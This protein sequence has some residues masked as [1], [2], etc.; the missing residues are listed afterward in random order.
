MY[1]PFWDKC[2]KWPQRTLKPT[3]SN[4]PITCVTWIPD[5]PIS[6]CFSLWPVVSE[7]QA[8]LRQMHQMNPQMT[9]EHYK[10]KATP[11]V[12]LVSQ[13]PNFQS[14]SLYDQLFQSY[15]S[16]DTNAL[17]DPQMTLNTRS[18]VSHMHVNRF[19]DTF[20]DKYIKWPWTLQGQIYP[21]YAL[22]FVLLSPS[23]NLNQFHCP[24]MLPDIPWEF[25]LFCGFRWIR[26][27]TPNGRQMLKC[28]KKKILLLSLWECCAPLQHTLLL[29]IHT[30]PFYGSLA[31]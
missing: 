6:V 16:F 5:S 18:N 15:R 23:P 3:R 26:L 30:I 28:K 22:N 1:R 31:E 13:S 24:F 17:N 19:W 7:L 29:H 12:L 2:T 27:L 20:W 25:P 9:L 10:V 11:Y 14:V 4:V 21:I 8:I